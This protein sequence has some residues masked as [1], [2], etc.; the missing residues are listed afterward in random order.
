MCYLPSL[1]CH[2]LTMRT[3]SHVLAVQIVLHVLACWTTSLVLASMVPTAGVS[4]VPT[5][6]TFE[7]FHLIGYLTV[8][9]GSVAHVSMCG[10][11]LVAVH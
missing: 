6:T 1:A 9:S 2:V 10:T 7:K 11:V 5:T 8:P 3:T 4:M